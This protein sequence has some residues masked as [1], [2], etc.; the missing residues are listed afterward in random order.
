MASSKT[1]TSGPGVTEEHIKNGALTEHQIIPE[2]KTE[3]WRSNRTWSTTY[4]R[5]TNCCRARQHDITE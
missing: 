2:A 4:H 1:L 5:T 3:H